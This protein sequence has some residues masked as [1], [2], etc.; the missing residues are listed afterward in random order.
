MPRL[1]RRQDD[2]SSDDFDVF[3]AESMQHCSCGDKRLPHELLGRRRWEAHGQLVEAAKACRSVSQKP[4]VAAWHILPRLVVIALLALAA[5]GVVVHAQDDV[6]ELQQRAL[7]VAS[8]A[9]L[10]PLASALAF[11]VKDA[12]RQ[13]G[14][15]HSLES[16]EEWTD[17]VVEDHG[18]A[19]LV[20]PFEE[21]TSALDVRAELLQ[22]TADD[23]E[24]ACCDGIQRRHHGVDEAGRL[25][26]DGYAGE[27]KPRLRLGAREA[28][29][30]LEAIDIGQVVARAPE[31]PEA[32][33]CVGQD[34]RQLQV[35]GCAKQGHCYLRRQDLCHERISISVTT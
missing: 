4:S 20:Q 35:S 31:V 34:W 17:A 30:R 7:P 5:V 18:L 24:V 19:L 15:F 23:V 27:N 14:V 11:V 10:P 29:K 21:N 3:A 8:A 28:D 22:G 9:E 6:E 32:C 26:L 2:V 33:G 1:L 25:G 16:G 12:S 13:P